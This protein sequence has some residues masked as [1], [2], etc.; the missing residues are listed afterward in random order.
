MNKK[1]RG[2]LVSHRMVLA[3]IFLLGA[4][5]G[6][7]MLGGGTTDKKGA[8]D[9]KNKKGIPATQICQMLAHPSFENNSAYNGAGCSG[10][11]YFG[12]RD[13]RTASYETD[14]RPA[15]SYGVIGEQ[16]VIT[17]V[18][19]SMTKRPDG[20][21][22]FLSEA[23]AVA[24]MINGQPLPKEIENA[25]VSPLLTSGGEFTTTSQIGNARVELVRS[26]SDSKF[27]LSF[28]F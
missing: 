27:Y 28:Q 9:P 7:K 8:D 14:M 5:L 11:T 15:F 26:S 1:Q 10:S 17:K 24:R 21:Q 3:L 25:I 6:C 20:A 4:S 18:I 22:F 23:D 19:L 13:T 2:A 16:G 12:I